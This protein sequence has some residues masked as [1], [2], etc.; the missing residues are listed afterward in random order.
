MFTF[1]YELAYT[2]YPILI[3]S[4]GI[5]FLVIFGVLGGINHMIFLAF[6]LNSELVAL[7]FFSFFTNIFYATLITVGLVQLEEL[8]YQIFAK[9]LA[10]K[11][12]LKI[13]R[14]TLV[15]FIGIQWLVVIAGSYFLRTLEENN[16]LGFTQ[17][18]RIILSISFLFFGMAGIVRYLLSGVVWFGVWLWNRFHIHITST[19]LQ[20]IG[21]VFLIFL[22]IYPFLVALG[23]FLFFWLET[24]LRAAEFFPLHAAIKNTCLSDP[25]RENCPQELRELSHIEPKHFAQAQEC[26]QLQYVYDAST[27]QYSFVV[28]YDAQR[29]V[30]F[31]QRFLEKEGIDFK[32]FSVDLL[33]KD[34]L[35]D[36]PEWPGPW[37][38]PDWEYGK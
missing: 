4:V 9:H 19:W 3:Y 27:Q 33:G 25:K 14:K 26:C 12:K 28:R 24:N 37:E 6:S 10:I 5:P 29:A 30:V 38:F 13:S 32:E 34:R 36:A 17:D 15:F 1:L 31:D 23:I 20:R 21:R 16:T 7:S 8:A 2:V 35:H 18:W 11:E 22:S